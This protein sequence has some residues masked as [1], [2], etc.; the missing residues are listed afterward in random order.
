VSQDI[1]IREKAQINL[2][3]L[4]VVF[5]VGGAERII[6]QTV[7]KLDKSKYKI[8][9]AAL[10]KGSGILINQLQI[11]GMH[12]VDLGM[13]S[14]LHIGAIY[15]LY[16]LIKKEH[17]DVIYSYLLQANIMGTI[18]GKFTKTPIMLFSLRSVA[19]LNGF[20]RLTLERLI[21][22]YSHKITAASK[23][24]MHSYK[25]AG[26]PEYKMLVIHNGVQVNKF[27][28]GNPLDKIKDTFIVGYVGNPYSTIKGHA[29]LIE[30]ARI[31]NNKN[32]NF[33]LIG[34]GK[35]MS[36]L[37][38]QA[39]ESGIESQIEFMGYCSDIPEQLAMMD[40]FVQPSLYEGMPNSVLEAMASG[41][42]II[43]TNVGG[44]PEAIIDNQTGFLIPPGEPQAIA[45]KI[46]YVIE[47]PD[48]ARQVG[49]N[50]REYIKKH[51]SIE[52]MVKKTDELFENVIAEKLGL[53]YDENSQQWYK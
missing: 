39:K 19:D 21:T 46:R 35:E 29:Y 24:I 33:R 13:H 6:A 20:I 1:R 10:R 7:E 14:K 25:A 12:V 5:D 9:V 53:I 8:T 47:N 3:Y 26:I 15:R 23:A 4:M 22:K 49:I 44:T 45:D 30:S 17:I 11:P 40:I 2:L 43:A 16:S 52:A 50:A 38:R 34:D 41:L 28:Y 18:V 27:I 51:F 32:I 36:N 48:I 42:P 31:L 37:I